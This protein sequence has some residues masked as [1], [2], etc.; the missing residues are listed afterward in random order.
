MKKNMFLFL[1]LGIPVVASSAP[2]K[3]T[4]KVASVSYVIRSGVDY[5]GIQVLLKDPIVGTNCSSQDIARGFYMSGGTSAQGI[6]AL[7]A[8]A[9]MMM[10]A[11]LQDLPITFS[12]DSTAICV[13]GYGVAW[14]ATPVTLTSPE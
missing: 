8:Y 11:Q 12:Y 3:I 5:L 9:S 4:S 13:V 14:P 7:K 2:L 1:L 6:E 10:T